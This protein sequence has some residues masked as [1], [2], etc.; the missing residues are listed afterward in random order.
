MVHAERLAGHYD[1]DVV[2]VGYGI[3]APGVRLERLRGRGREGQ[4]RGGAGERPRPQGLDAS[5][6]GKILT[7][8]GRW[9]YKIEEAARQG[10]AGILLVHTT[11]S[12][13]YPWTTVRPRWTG[14]AGTAR[15]SRPTSLLVAGWLQHEAAARLFRE[16]RPGPRRADAS[17][18]PPGG[19]RP[20][21]SGSG[22]RP[23]S[24][25]R[26]AGQTTDNVM[27][28]LPGRGALAKRG[29]AHR[30]PLRPL[31]HQRAGERRLDLQRG[32]RTTPR[33]PPQ[34]WPRPRHSSEAAC[35]PDG[36]LCSWPSPPRSPGSWALR[37]W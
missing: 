9:T 34:C 32:A 25:A 3:V 35:A 27:A 30:R 10:A 18:P 5:S 15:S 19:S 16:R 6:A 11:E 21:R 23:P 17:E 36:R 29:G 24:G 14:P 37:R 4:D 2:F 13:T 28:R 20:C 12:A 26:S 31:R 7:Y 33:E 1:G 8:Y 22:S